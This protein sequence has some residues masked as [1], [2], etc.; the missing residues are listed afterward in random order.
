M[1][2]IKHIIQAVL[3]ENDAR[4]LDNAEEREIIA[5]KCTAKLTAAVIKKV[6]SMLGGFVDTANGCATLY[7][8]IKIEG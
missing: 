4:C 1:N 3:E 8:N 7:T 2:Q 5:E 6:A